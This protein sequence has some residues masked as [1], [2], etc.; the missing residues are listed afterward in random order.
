MAIE[1]FPPFEGDEKDNL[2]N[3]KDFLNPDIIDYKEELLNPELKPVLE[4]PEDVEG[5]FE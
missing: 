3:D 2:N 5:S 1:R 4:K